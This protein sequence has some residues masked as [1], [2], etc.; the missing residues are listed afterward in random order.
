MART[1]GLLSF[2]IV[3]E[4]LLP[5]FFG[6]AINAL[7]ASR[8]KANSQQTRP[9]GISTRLGQTGVSHRSGSDRRKFLAAS[10][11]FLHFGLHVGAKI[12]VGLLFG[13]AVANATPWE[14]IGTVTHVQTIGFLPAHVF[15]VLVLRFH[16]W[17]A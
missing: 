14:Q 1:I 10:V 4:L 12:P 3:V 13:D 11:S 15:E 7:I 9:D 6:H 2:N 8:Q 17:V 5:E 16:S